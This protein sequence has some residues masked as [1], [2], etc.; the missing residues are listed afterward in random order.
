MP[1]RV[2]L[3]EAGLHCPPHLKELKARKS[4]KEK[5]NV[6]WASKFSRVVTL[7][8]L[9]SLVSD[10]KIDMPLYNISPTATLAKR[11]VCRFN[12]VNEFYDGTLNSICAYAFSTIALDMSNNKVFTY[13]KAMHQPNSA[14]FLEAMSKEIDDHQACPHWEKVQRTMIP[15]RHNT[16]QAIWSFKRKRFPDGTLNKNKARLCAHEGMQQWGVSY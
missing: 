8:T 16:V 6:T 14:Q 5:A 3:H 2:N 15:P 10:M 12:E 9:Y 13:T 11:A 1:Q 4:T 7:L